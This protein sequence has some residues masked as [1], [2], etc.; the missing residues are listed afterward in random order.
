MYRHTRRDRT[1]PA[2]S[3]PPPPT[4]IAVIIYSKKV[5]TNYE[6]NEKGEIST[7]FR[8]NARQMSINN[9]VFI[10]MSFMPS[11]PPKVIHDVN[12]F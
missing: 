2:P 6:D 10:C 11:I 3:P 12:L 4:H 9:E 7:L 5:S 8:R 1:P